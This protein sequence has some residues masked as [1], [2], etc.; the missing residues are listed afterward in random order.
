MSSVNEFV[1]GLLSLSTSESTVSHV[2]SEMEHSLISTPQRKRSATLAGLR[3]SE[4]PKRFCNDTPTRRLVNQIQP[5]QNSPAVAVS[6]DLLVIVF[7]SRIT[8]GFSEKQ[9]QGTF[10][11]HY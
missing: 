2:T 4:T 7:A 1:I 8:I 10:S 6:N 5:S 3:S 11:F 9:E